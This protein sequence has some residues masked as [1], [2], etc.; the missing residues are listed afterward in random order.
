[1]Y[2]VRRIYE[3]IK[4]KGINRTLHKIVHRTS[5]NRKYE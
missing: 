5:L 1:M 4:A 2:H 3:G